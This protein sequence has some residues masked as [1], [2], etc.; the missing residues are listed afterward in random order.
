MTHYKRSQIFVHWLTAILLMVCLAL[1][2]ARDTFAPLLG[3][4][5]NLFM[6]HKSLAVCIIVITLYRLLLLAIHG[7][8]KVL[9]DNQKIQL[10]ASHLVHASLY[11]LIIGMFVAG[12]MMSS[13]PINVFNLFSIPVTDLSAGTRKLAHQLHVTLPYALIALIVLHIVAALY[14]H[15]IVKDNVLRSMIRSK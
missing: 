14:H 13:N 3:G 7:R 12:Y 6:L 8:P 10:V 15:F 1:P 2:L 11:I 9:E 5:G 4:M